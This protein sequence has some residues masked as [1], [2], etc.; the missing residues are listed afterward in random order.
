MARIIVPNQRTKI[1]FFYLARKFPLATLF[2][3]F[4]GFLSAFI[5]VKI[6]GDIGKLIKEGNISSITNNPWGITVRLIS[7]GLVVF[8]HIAMEIYLTEFYS[9]H[10]RQKLV[11]KYLRTNLSQAQKA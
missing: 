3:Y 6:L 9:S 10:L 1:S 5:V 2:H 4:T 7:F 8:L 11:D